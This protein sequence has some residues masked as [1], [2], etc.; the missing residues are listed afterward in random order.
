[1]RRRAELMEA[2]SAERQ[3]VQTR[4]AE[5]E[6]ALEAARQR[7]LRLLNEASSLKNRITQIDAQLATADRD[8]LVPRRK[9][10]RASRIWSASRAS[11]RSLVS[12]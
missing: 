12:G 3:E 4:F 6:R 8:T 11:K 5:Q 2:K 7:V 9:N 10:S 1:M